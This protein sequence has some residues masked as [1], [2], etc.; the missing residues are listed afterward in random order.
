MHAFYLITF[1]LWNFNPAISWRSLKMEK[2][3]AAAI[4]LKV[5][6]AFGHIRIRCKEEFDAAVSAN[7]VL[8]LYSYCTNISVP[9]SKHHVYS[10]GII[11]NLYLC[12]REMVG[13]RPHILLDQ[14]ER[15]IQPRG[16]VPT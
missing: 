8:M 13:L 1:I 15:N 2:H 6:I 14:L 4:H 12:L 9:N 5:E 11:G 3:G 10:Y 16:S 7:T